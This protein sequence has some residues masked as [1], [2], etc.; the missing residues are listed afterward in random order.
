MSVELGFWAPVITAGAL[1]G[2]STGLLGVY[3]IGMR[4][5]FLGVCVA[6]AALAGA[7]FGSL[8]GLTGQALLVPA[9]VAA[10]ATALALGLADPRRLRADVNV[11]MGLL[12]T[13]TMGLAFLGVGLFPRFG[14]SASEA[15][16]LLWGSLTFCSWRDVAL[17]VP[18][19][20]VEVAFVLLFYKEMRAIMFSREHAAAAG[21]R[22]GL[23]WTAFLFLASAV[24][25]VNFKIVG[26]L[27]IYSL[28]ANPAAAAFQLVRGH[29]RA[30]VLAVALGTVSGVGGFL[31]ALVAELPTG[32]TIVILSSAL[33]GAAALGARLWGL[34][35][36]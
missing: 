21:V 17:M 26:G 35:R 8:A 29:G 13:L 31:I 11:V 20:A 16:G 12:F 22:V 7:V 27:M 9:L 36:Q 2:A 33:V 19:T 34:K 24:L 32:A 6:H 15:F 30:L 23:V 28:M 4:I 5:P 14:R 3:I 1:A 10:L 18:L 25:T